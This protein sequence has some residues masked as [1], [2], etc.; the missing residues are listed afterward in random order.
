VDL[1]TAVSE[2]VSIIV[3]LCRAIWRATFVPRWTRGSPGRRSERGAVIPANFA[4]RN[5]GGT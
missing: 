3:P 1:I 5:D 4:A 2:H